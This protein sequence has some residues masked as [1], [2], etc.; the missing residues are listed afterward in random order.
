M[1]NNDTNTDYHKFVRA[2]DQMWEIVEITIR[3]T[4]FCL[5]FVFT[6]VYIGSFQKNHPHLK[7]QFPP[8]IPIWS[9]SLLYKWTEKWLSPPP[10]YQKGWGGCV[11]KLWTRCT[12]HIIWTLF[13]D[14]WLQ[15]WTGR[16]NGNGVT[17]RKLNNTYNGNFVFKVELAFFLRDSS[18]SLEGR[19]FQDT[20]LFVLV[21]RHVSEWVH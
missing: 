21:Q 10:Y 16:L 20:F 18:L 12:S 13:L 14:G 11:C 2:G 15:Y 9:K 19:K 8:K 17:S 6:I 5:R 4:F 1:E 3:I 7:C